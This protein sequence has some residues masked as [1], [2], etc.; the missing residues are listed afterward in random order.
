MALLYD[1]A[2]TCF[3]PALLYQRLIK[4]KYRGNFLKRFGVDFPEIEKKKKLIWLHAVSLGE[5]KAI[6]PLAKKI[7]EEFADSRIIVSSI[8]ETGHA[9]AKKS[10]PF[11]DAHFFLPFD[12]S[13]IIRPI[14]RRLSPDLIIL[15]E[16]DL[17]L[18]FLTAGKEAG[19]KI[20]L[21]NGKL[22]EKSMRRYERFPFAARRVWPQIDLFCVQ[23]EIYK[24]RFEKVGVPGE[25]MVV[26]GNIKHDREIKPLDEG[27]KAGF[28]ERLGILPGE[29]VV[30]AASTHDPEERMFLSA[31]K[32]IWKEHPA[33]KALLAPRHPER[34][35]EA[36][37]LLRDEKI[38]FQ[39]YS[40]LSNPSEKVILVDRM[41]MLD[42]CFQIA[43]LALVGGSFTEKVGGHNI[44]EPCAYGTPVLFGPYMHSQPDMTAMVLEYGAGRQ[45]GLGRMAEEISALLRRPEER[46][47]LGESG[48]KLMADCRGAAE[49]TF[50]A[51]LP[52]W[53][54]RASDIV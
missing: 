41:G 5:T 51:I 25:R 16:T 53:Q 8:T 24:Q 37:E 4:G 52:L 26:T 47:A 17:W 42:N 28:R 33:A 13:W 10:I 19:A 1:L 30:V 50:S 3:L 44:L 22:S 48:L 32:E 18:N 21:V 46:R 54:M 12:L 27:E 7:K 40:E 14:V 20:A 35:D 45:I 29:R 31:L 39:R 38:P 43:D 36:A 34:F 23:S 2:L 49:R 9:E 6:A 15:S 11:A